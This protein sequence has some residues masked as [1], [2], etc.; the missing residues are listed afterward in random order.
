MLKLSQALDDK[1]FI[2]HLD[3][4]DIED[5]FYLLHP[6]DRGEFINM[7]LD[8]DV[9]KQVTSDWFRSIICKPEESHLN[10]LTNWQGKEYE[11]H[12]PKVIKTFDIL[13]SLNYTNLI[14][15]N[16][17]GSFKVVDG[18]PFDPP[19]DVINLEI[20]FTDKK[21]GDPLFCNIAF[22]TNKNNGF[23]FI[24]FTDEDQ[25]NVFDTNG[26]VDPTFVKRQ[27]IRKLNELMYE[28]I[29]F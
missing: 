10:T 4:L 28:L 1:N 12:D 6:E 20:D 2:Y 27:M 11:I 17:T 23:K 7:L 29:Q 16:T 21:K 24:D 8:E 26:N 3:N 13:L 19:L 25:V 5:C 15:N 22:F 18:K 14:N 9:S